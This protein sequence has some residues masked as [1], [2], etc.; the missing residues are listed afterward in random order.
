MFDKY[1][2]VIVLGQPPK[3]TKDSPKNGP[4]LLDLSASND[5]DLTGDILPV[6][7]KSESDLMP[8]NSQTDLE[9][10]GD[11]FSSLEASTATATSQNTPSLL[12]DT[13]IMQPV[14]ISP[15]VPKGWSYLPCMIHSL[16]KNATRICISS[17]IMS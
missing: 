2:A 16:A 6:N 13:T 11:I 8:K 9:M 7:K 12:S 14:S 4:S 5:L 17:L 3:K 1:I 15:L 10:L